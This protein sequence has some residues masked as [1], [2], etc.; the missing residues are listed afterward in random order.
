MRTLSLIILSAALAFGSSYGRKTVEISPLAPEIE[1]MGRIVKDSANVRF[2]YPGVT[3]LVNFEGE[4]LA[5]KANPGAGKFMVEIDGGA[6]QKVVFAESDSVI[7]IAD[8]LAPSRP[9]RARITYAIEGYEKHPQWRGF[10]IE[11]KK[12]RILPAT[13]PSGPKIM[14]IG[15]SITCGYGTETTDP[16][17][18]FSYDNENHTL[19]YAYL[20]ARDLDADFHVVA[21]SGI[22]IYR[23]YAGP[24][25]GSDW[26]TMPLEFDNALIYDPSTRWDHSSF[27]PDII[28]INLGTND[29]SLGDYDIALYEQAMSTFHARL[30]ALYPDAA[31]VLLSGCMLSPEVLA[32]IRPAFARIAAGD[33]NTYCLNFLPHMDYLGYGADMHP[34][35]AQHQIMGAQLS[36]FLRTLPVASRR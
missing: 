3:S 4:R 8:S 20:A 6:P 11:G 7:V 2:N 28:C 22:G 17:E 18:H 1:Y 25:T 9:H 32:D 21:R 15:N 14:F 35:A 23:N 36:N 13:R 27:S 31:I 33:A 29:T 12:P 5:M 16:Y 34:S 26:G 24:R 30:R 10:A 19:T